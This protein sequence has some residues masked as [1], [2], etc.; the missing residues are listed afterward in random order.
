MLLEGKKLTKRFGGLLAVNKLSFSIRKGEMLGLIGPNGSGKSTL[1]NLL[2]GFMPVTSGEILYQGQNITRLPNHSVARLGISRTFQAV[3]IFLN[4]TVWDNIAVGCIAK[5]K[6]SVW[7]ALS[8]GRKNDDELLSEKCKEVLKTIKLEKYYGK[9]AGE[10]DQ[11]KQKRVAIGIAL[12]T[13]PNL[14]LLDEPTGGI[15]IEEI[16]RLMDIIQ[17]VS[18]KGVTICLIEHKMKMV[19][20]L[21]ERIIVLNYGQKIA[22]GSPAE[23]IRNE[24]AIKAYLGDE[25]AA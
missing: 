19:M 9:I 17:R 21:C 10:L 7:D 24:E 20:D 23:I 4:E 15:N 22:E 2:T 14:L 11:E 5:A 12:A 6:H 18:D 13:D 1:F 25:Y 3:K 16:S 8:R